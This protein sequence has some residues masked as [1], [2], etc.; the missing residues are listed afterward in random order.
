[1]LP[2]GLLLL[3]ASACQLFTEAATGSKVIFHGPDVAEAGG[4][5][6]VHLTYQQ[7]I[8]GKLSIYYGQCDFKSQDAAHHCLGRTHIGRHPLA[9]RHLEWA[10]NRPTRFVWLPPKDLP[11]AYCLHAFADDELVGSSNP[12]QIARR[13]ARRRES[14]ADIADPEGPWFDGVEYLQQKEPDDSFVAQAKNK[15]IG[16]V[17]GGMSGL[18]TAVSGL[19]H[20]CIDGFYRS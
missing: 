6:N 11:S 3:S 15:K 14:F 16:I 5:R 13:K 7:P 8:D 10:E 20:Q 4:M 1:M 12:I 9:K 19:S 17:G 2:F 18:M